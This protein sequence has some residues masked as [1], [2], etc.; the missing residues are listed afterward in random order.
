MTLPLLPTYYTKTTVLERPMVKILFT[1]R[2]ISVKARIR[3]IRSFDQ[4]PTHLYQGYTLILDGEA[5]GAYRNRF[6]VAIGPKAHE[7]HRFRIGDAI[8][9]RAIPVPDAETEWAGF[10]KVSGLQLIERT[11][12]GDWPPGPD[13]GTAPP[14]EQYRVRGHF[15]LKRETCETECVQCPFGLTMP[16]QIILDHWYPPKVKWCIET[17]CYGP[18]GCPRYKAGPP[19]RVP[20][21]SSGMVY[22]DDDVERAARGE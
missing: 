20:G 8:R 10:Y 6:K 12:P 3:L 22:V 4:I 15:R 18:R 2:I 13:G 16:T 9:G 19:Y 17:H 11:H 7:Q 1:G 21:R 5:G 14:L